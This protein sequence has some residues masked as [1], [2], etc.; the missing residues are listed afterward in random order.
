MP[1]A[2]TLSPTPAT[3]WPRRDAGGSPRTRWPTPAPGRSSTSSASALGADRLLA[4]HA[5]GGLDLAQPRHTHQL[6]LL[7]GR[8]AFEPEL[9]PVAQLY[10][11]HGGVLA[12]PAEGGHQR[13][14][15]GDG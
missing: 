8:A 14:A 5:D 9:H 2:W 4:L 15:R 10:G 12:A 11:G 3:T 7:E 1:T 13:V 6:G